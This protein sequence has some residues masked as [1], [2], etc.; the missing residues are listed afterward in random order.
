MLLS[1]E[2]S[3]IE[4]HIKTK[5]PPQQLSPTNLFHTKAVKRA[6]KLVTETS[7][8]L[9]NDIETDGYIERMLKSRKIPQFETKQDSM[10]N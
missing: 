5:M 1:I 6:V 4:E 8:Y 2:S 7:T 9:K 3:K 10:I